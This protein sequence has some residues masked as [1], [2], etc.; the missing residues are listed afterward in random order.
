MFKGIEIKK[1]VLVSTL[2]CVLLIVSVSLYLIFSSRANLREQ[3]DKMKMAMAEQIASRLQSCYASMTDYLMNNK[4]MELAANQQGGQANLDAIYDF[5][6]SSVLGTYD[7]DFIIYRTGTGKVISAAKSGL[8]VPDISAD[9]AS[10]DEDYVIINELGDRKGTFF[11]LSKPGIFPSDEVVLGIDNTVQVDTIKQAYEDEKSHMVK[12]QVVVVSILF[13]L[14]LLL[15]LM[16]IHF[17]ITR[18]LGRPMERLNGK[19]RD[20]TRGKPAVVEEV[21]EGSIFANLQRLVNSGRVILERGA[22]VDTADE[23][24]E[25][26]VERREVNKV[27]AVW[28]LITTLLFLVS[29]VVLLLASIAMMNSRTDDMVRNVDR[30]MAGYYSSCYDSI[31]GYS[32]ANTGVY[33]GSDIW[34]P[35]FA[36]DREASIQH[37][38]ILLKYAFN[39]DADVTNLGTPPGN[40]NLISVEEGVELK[41]PLPTALGDP[42]T[43]YENYYQQGDLVIMMMNPVNYPGYGENQFEYYIVNVTPQANALEGLYREGASSLLKGQLRLSLLFLLL[44]L[45]L[46]PLAM[47]WATRKYVTRPILE[48]D[49]LSSR[50]MEGELD[51]DI[52]VDEKSAFADIQRLLVRAQELLRSI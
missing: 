13:L 36:G 28:A 33:V 27:I 49:E 41:E 46:S 31:V 16:I 50:L 24:S 30:E 37:L 17:S 25:K 7:A 11:I 5:F 43:I 2:C 47:A 45:A 26:P 4:G 19:A 52:V 23:A 6:N 42:V 14:L 1:L 22:K 20:M 15:S 8:K 34:D 39:C 38:T 48:L 9:I 32:K 3:T 18:W 21:R 40:K 35:N 51:E 10:G 29:T 12:E 44:C